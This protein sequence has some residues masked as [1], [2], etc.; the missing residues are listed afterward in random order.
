MSTGVC[1][2]E[3][4]D[5]NTLVVLIHEMS[6][7]YFY[8]QQWLHLCPHNLKRF[9]KWLNPWN[10]ASDEVCNVQISVACVRTSLC[11]KCWSSVGF[12]VG[13]LEE[14]K[15]QWLFTEYY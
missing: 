11:W 2:G 1:C 6:D 7:E 8:I 5:V 3:G 4:L 12:T 15:V 13:M 14:Y 9:L 10:S